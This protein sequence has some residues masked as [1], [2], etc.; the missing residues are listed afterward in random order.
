LTEIEMPSRPPLLVA[1]TGGIASGK[2]AVAA[3]FANL[4]VPVLDT[5]QI[6]R[7]VVAPG[8]IVLADLAKTFG[9][10]VLDDSG[11]L[12]RARLRERVFSNPADREKLE[13]IM[14]PA[15][16]AELSRR[17]EVAG[18]AYQIH[19]IPLLVE[20]GRARDYDRVLVVDCPE[21]LQIARLMERDDIDETLANQMLNAQATREQRLACA[22]DVI[23]NTGTLDDLDAFVETLHKNYSLLADRMS[24]S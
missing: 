15:I 4:G 6:A 13:A 21:N 8:S 16:R 5:D 11:A 14:H 17:T 19:V 3:L 1:L 24:P 22:D 2:S 20:T 23:V 18:G 10:D 7:D 12:N 9:R